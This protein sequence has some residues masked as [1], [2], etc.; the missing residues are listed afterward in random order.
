M[1]QMLLLHEDYQVKAFSRPGKDNGIDAISGNGQIVYQAKYHENPS[2]SKCIADLQSEMGKIG[3]YKETLEYW[4]PV[5]KWVL[6]TN[7]EENPNDRQKWEESVKNCDCHVLE[8]ELW[9]WP[10]IWTLLEKYPEVKKEYI[11]DEVRCFLQE[12]EFLENNRNSY[13]PESYDVECVGRNNELQKF[14]EFLNSNKKVWAISGPGGMGKSRF[15]LECAKRVNRNDR[16]VFFGMPQVMKISSSWTQR[17]VFEH[18]SILFIDELNDINLLRMLVAVLSNEAK[19]WKVVFSERNADAQTIKELNLPRYESIRKDT[20]SLSRLNYQNRKLFTERLLD[21]IETSRKIEFED[22]ERAAHNICETSQGIPLWIC[23]TLK[24]ILQNNG[25]IGEEFEKNAAALYE[26]YTES[27]IPNLDNNFI[28]NEQYDAVLRWSSLYRA[29]SLKQEKII[30]F[31]CLKANVDKPKL[32][33]LFQVMT[34]NGLMQNYGYENKTYSICPDV[35]REYILKERLLFNQKLSNWGEEVIDGLIHNEIPYPNAV[36]ESL[37]HIENTISGK[38][39]VDVLGSF[40]DSLKKKFETSDIDDHR[41][42]WDLVEKLCASKTRETLEIVCT[43]L[44]KYPVNKDIYNSLWT[45][46]IKIRDILQNCLYYCEDFCSRQLCLEN[47]LILCKTGRLS[48]IENQSLE[49]VLHPIFEGDLRALYKENVD[50]IMSNYFEVIEN[51]NFS[52]DDYS[53]LKSLL[54]GCFSAKYNTSVCFN[55]TLSLRQSYLGLDAI[56]DSFKWVKRIQNILEEKILPE[57]LTSI[58]IDCYGKIFHEVL[59]YPSYYLNQDTKKIKEEFIS[60]QLQWT[61]SFISSGQGLNPKIR[62]HMREVVWSWLLEYGKEYDSWELAKKCEEAYC[63][64]KT[65]EDVLSY[66]NMPYDENEKEVRTDLIKKHLLDKEE[67]QVIA[68]VDKLAFYTTHDF[69]RINNIAFEYGQS[70]QNMDFIISIT[71]QLAQRSSNKIFEQFYLSVINGIVSKQSDVDSAIIFIRIF[72]KQGLDILDVLSSCLGEK[73]FFCINTYNL[74]KETVLDKDINKY[75]LLMSRF[76]LNMPQDFLY[77]IDSLWSKWSDLNKKI[78]LG[79]LLNDAYASASGWSQNSF[80]WNEF[81]SNWIIEKIAQTEEL[82]SFANEIHHFEKQKS[83]FSTRK[84]IQWLYSVFLFR[85]DRGYHLSRNFSLT[86]FVE[87]N[88]DENE[89]IA[90][91]NIIDLLLCWQSSRV[92]KDIALLDP[93]N[94]C[95]GQI[96]VEKFKTAKNDDERHTYASIASYLKDDTS[97]WLEIAAEV[98]RYARRLSDEEKQSFWSDLDWHEGIF[99]SSA[100]G[101]VAKVF[102]ENVDHYKCML[103]RESQMARKD[104]WISRLDIAQ[105]ELRDAEERAKVQRGE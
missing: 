59:H 10:T 55:G 5:K 96:V 101:E 23:L 4:K 44:D 2:I 60:E 98:C 52:N 70:L 78:F 3:E 72:L 26:K 34:K 67:N 79:R 88:F 100:I 15:L 16:N 95:V 12:R 42:L 38:E 76:T 90:F 94:K 19:N 37:S 56:S 69:Y 63:L 86:Y 1:M 84:N 64:N 28:S 58:L 33:K 18:P 66:I 46:Y 85:K 104:Y 20:C 13:L 21:V 92:K 50:E 68:F 39:S 47:I 102:Y 54:D 57:E 62:N 32:E 53:I 83:L 51:D 103:K 99:S 80:E 49:S 14:D 87:S 40:T 9:N 93:E 97:A 8:I 22:K 30:D 74:V 89:R 29:I 7:I 25:S 45:C 27:I 81:A 73:R 82:D 11:D 48:V 61:A 36:V 77:E 91:A 75:V 24:S 43:Q 105:S 71:Q 35:I 31:I 65:D 17:L 6:F 41:Q